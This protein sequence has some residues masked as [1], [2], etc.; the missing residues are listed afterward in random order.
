MKLDKSNIFRILMWLA[1]LLGGAV[2]CIHFDKKY[3]LDWFNN[4]YFH[5]ATIIPGYFLLKLVLKIS[6]NTGR[7]L[8]EKGREGNI[9]RMQTNR[10]VTDGVYARMRHPM[11][12]GLLFFPLAFALLLGSPSF[13]FILAPIEVLLMIVLI[14]FVE[15][16]EAEKKFGQAYRDYKKQTPMFCLSLK[17]VKELL[18][19]K[20][21]L[22]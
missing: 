4:L 6:R 18:N 7:L 5:I 22:Q 1:M 20:K 3:F 9:P 15:E 8:A 14:K 16:K 2:V 11:H 19:A 21:N 13:I 10:L 17:C 12:L